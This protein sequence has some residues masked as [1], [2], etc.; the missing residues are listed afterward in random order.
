MVF[1]AF[2]QYLATNL[3]INNFFGG[4]YIS[5]LFAPGNDVSIYFF[6]SILQVILIFIF[7]RM[8]MLCKKEATIFHIYR[9]KILHIKPSD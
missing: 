9:K 6:S 8:F 7:L 1:F 3:H 2:H 4:N 5:V